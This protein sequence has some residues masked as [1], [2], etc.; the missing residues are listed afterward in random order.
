M[1]SRVWSDPR[2]L[3]MMKEDFVVCALYADDK[4]ALPR[5]DWVTT[6]DGKILKTLG[7]VN[8]WFALTRFNV[9]AQPYYAILDPA[10]EEHKVP[11][12]G[13]NLDVEAFLAFLKAGLE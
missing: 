9:N 5:E 13:Y 12:R 2:V 1:E 11:S 3:K 4:K 8:S 10:T 6:P 7:K